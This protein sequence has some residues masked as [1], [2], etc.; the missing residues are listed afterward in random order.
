MFRSRTLKYKQKILFGD[1]VLKVVSM[2]FYNET[3]CKL[4]DG[5]IR[6]T[7]HLN[8]TLFIFFHRPDGFMTLQ[9]EN[10]V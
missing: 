6:R 2:V 10:D 7:F 1:I 9:T 4:Y 3:L 5:R 8:Q